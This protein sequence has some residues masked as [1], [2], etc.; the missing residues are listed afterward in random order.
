MT[1]ICFFFS[2]YTYT[3]IE[4][5]ETDRKLKERF[6]EHK[7]YVNNK[8]LNQP[9]GQHFNLPGHSIANMTITI[10]EKVRKPESLYRKEREKYHIRK[11]NT[12]YE[13]MNKMA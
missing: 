6:S 7:G 10:V 12:Y 5:G 9:T 3:S 13:G 1:L 8:I 11:F 4:D 2:S